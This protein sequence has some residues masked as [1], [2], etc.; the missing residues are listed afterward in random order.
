MDTLLGLSASEKGAWQWLL[1]RDQE[2]TQLA[3]RLRADMEAV[4]G[5]IEAR[6]DLPAGA[7]G[8]THR[9]NLDTGAVEAVEDGNRW[10]QQP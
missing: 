3:A 9:V 7:I 8:T 2:L 4:N 5:E 10:P 1:A 6:L